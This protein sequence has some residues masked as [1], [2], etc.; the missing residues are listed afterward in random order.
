MSAI[1]KEKFP[2]GAL[3]AAAALVV[4]SIVG[5]GV[6]RWQNLNKPVAAEALA[7]TPVAAVDL[8][9]FD[10][11]D[12][13]VTVRDA[14]SGATVHVFEPGTNGFLRTALRG[15]ASER[16]RAGLDREPP[17]RVA[18]W[19]DGRITLQDTA[20]GRFLNGRAFGD[21]QLADISNLLDR[22]LSAR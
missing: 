19:S 10:E 16:R 8:Q 3:Y 13:S 11:A 12:G 9:F 18:R 17:F 7:E 2:Q 20:T 15:M 14:Q 22:G 21:D 1:D 5:A 6:G 4:L